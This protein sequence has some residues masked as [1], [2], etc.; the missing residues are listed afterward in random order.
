MDKLPD[1]VMLKDSEESDP[2]SGYIRFTR[3]GISND[4]LSAVVEYS[5]ISA[6]LAG[7]GMAA[8]L[9]KQDGVWVLI[10]LQM[11]WVS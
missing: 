9:E 11:M 2:Y 5:S 4:G 8:V 3:P 1:Y 7:S 10:W 6:P